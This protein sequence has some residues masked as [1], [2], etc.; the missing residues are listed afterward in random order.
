MIRNKTMGM[1]S[2]EYRVESYK[3]A[4]VTQS[5]HLPTIGSHSGNSTF[6]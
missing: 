4:E 5:C 1:V 3:E 6:A 2:K